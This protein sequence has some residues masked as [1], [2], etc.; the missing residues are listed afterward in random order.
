VDISTGAIQPSPRIFIARQA[1]ASCSGG[2]WP[3]A[4]QASRNSDLA[5]LMSRA[6]PIGSPPGRWTVTLQSQTHGIRSVANRIRPMR[7]LPS[8][9]VAKADGAEFQHI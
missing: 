8:G 6:E 5:V 1:A 7:C 4:L 3:S 2:V 9:K